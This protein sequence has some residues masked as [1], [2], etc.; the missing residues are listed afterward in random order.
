VSGLPDAPPKVSVVVMTYNHRRYIEQALDSALS[1][2]TTF[3][4]E[5]LISED[6]STDGTRE[7]V[8]DYQRRHPQRIRLLLSERNLRSNAVVA[9]GINAARGQ[10]VAMLDGDDYWTRDD[11]LQRQADFLDAHPQCTMCF[12]NARVVHE[13][14]S[15]PEWNWV[16]GGQ[17][18]FSTLEDM[19][20]GNFVPMCSV[21]YRNGVIGPVP[22]W[23]VEFD[24]SPTLITD[25]QLH[26]LHAE[27]GLI[28]YID[29]VMGVYRQHGGGLYSHFS[30]REKQAMTLRFYRKM[31]DALE[32]R[33][34]QTVDV[35]ISR[36]FLEW[37]EEYAK[38]GDRKRGRECFRTCLQGR[39]VN[40]YVS[41]RRLLA[42]AA[43]LWLPVPWQ[44]L[45]REQTAQP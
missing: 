7:L 9:R 34:Q 33:H 26:L 41:R 35:A 44:F 24:M 10:Y 11:K 1:Q 36:Y 8:I 12:H 16:P 20:M 25:W 45:R 19:W 5:L 31:N 6:C 43:R 27:R 22:D 29:E 13:D 4:W 40:E 3:G 2:R 42:A 15:R 32:H 17:K 28:G 30:E 18:V 21:M 14:G 23:Y 37:A 38:R 39:P